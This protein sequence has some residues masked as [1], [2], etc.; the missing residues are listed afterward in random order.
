MH[1]T[2][3]ADESF[4]TFAIYKTSVFKAQNHQDFRRFKPATYQGTRLT[5]SKEYFAPNH[6]W[7]QPIAAISAAESRMQSELP[8][9]AG[10]KM[11]KKMHIEAIIVQLTAVLG[12]QRP[13]VPGQGQEG[14]AL[15]SS[16]PAGNCGEI[17]AWMCHPQITPCTQLKCQEK[18]GISTTEH[19]PTLLGLSLAEMG[20]RVGYMVGFWR[21][22]HWD[23]RHSVFPSVGKTEGRNAVPVLDRMRKG[24]TGATLAQRRAAGTG[25]SPLKGTTKVL[26]TAASLPYS[27]L[28]QTWPK[29]K[30]KETHEEHMHW[31]GNTGGQGKSSHFLPARKAASSAQTSTARCSLT[32]LINVMPL[33]DLPPG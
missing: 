19:I 27:I 21:K 9:Q 22:N 31:L 26:L 2:Q 33:K 15:T 1:L 8:M 6:R 25:H 13:R 17:K 32:F 23:G 5:R 14:R 30:T 11:G 12:S 3:G 4:F 16:V 7:P 29:I 10:R 20:T 18:Q 24:G 28:S